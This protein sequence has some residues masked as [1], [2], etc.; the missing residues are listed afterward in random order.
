MSK[1]QLT[2]PVL[3]FA[4]H[5]LSVREVTHNH[6]WKLRVFISKDPINGMISNIM[7]IRGMIK[8]IVS[9]IDSTDLNR[10]DFL[11]KSQRECPTCEN[12]CDF[13]L[14]KLSLNIEEI[15]GV[16]VTLFEIDEKDNVKEE[17]GSVVK[18]K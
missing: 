2:I 4:K 8:T 14:E 7:N 17:W 16:E 15:S 11:S 3:F 5:S 9:L 13:F 10:N 18:M 12:L 1:Y 6:K